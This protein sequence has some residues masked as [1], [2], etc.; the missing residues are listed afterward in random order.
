MTKTVP[1]KYLDSGVEGVDTS[2]GLTIE[3]CT[4]CGALTPTEK[5]QDHIDRHP[6]WT[7]PEPPPPEVQPV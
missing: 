1:V 6:A 4:I 7:P 3:M 5:V 2:G